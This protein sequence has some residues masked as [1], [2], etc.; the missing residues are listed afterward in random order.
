MMAVA[1]NLAWPG[2]TSPSAGP[3]P[4]DRCLIDLDPD[5]FEEPAREVLAPHPAMDGRD[6]TAV[7][8][9]GESLALLLVQLGAVARRLAVEEPRGTVCGEAQHPVTHDLEGDAANPGRVRS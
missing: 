4:S 9:P 5:L 7:H 8:D 1:D 3:S 2:P 6:R